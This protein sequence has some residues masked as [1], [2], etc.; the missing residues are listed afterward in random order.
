MR[1]G[2]APEEPLVGKEW[3]QGLKLVIAKVTVVFYTALVLH[4]LETAQFCGEQPG[5]AELV[6]VLWLSR[7][8]PG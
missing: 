2:A 3:G 8:R 1:S 6:S 5:M 4:S 7:C